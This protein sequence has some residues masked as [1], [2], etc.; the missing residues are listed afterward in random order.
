MNPL[1]AIIDLFVNL[2]FI[3]LVARIILPLFRVN[4]YS[5]LMRVLYQLTEPILAP[6]RAILPQTGMF[7]FSPMVAMILL[8][9]V[10]SVLSSLLS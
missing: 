1:V 6:I 9:V 10:Q 5:P 3:V 7:D 4:P 8:T 2:Y